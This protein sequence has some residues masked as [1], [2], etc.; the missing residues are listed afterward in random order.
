[1]LD[2]LKLLLGISEEDETQDDKLQW[3]IDTTSTRLCILLGGEKEVPETLEYI[4]VEVA[5]IRFNR[6][7]SEGYASHS[8]EGESISFADDDFAGYADDMQA[9]ANAQA[10]KKTGKVKFI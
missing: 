9:W 4:V 7:G 10:D 5:A 2:N 8:V 3:I 1:M 6:I